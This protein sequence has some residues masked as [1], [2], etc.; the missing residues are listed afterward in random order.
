ME[1]EYLVPIH[2]E[3]FRDVSGFG[4]FY[5]I[6]SKGRLLSLARGKKKNA[7]IR[8]GFMSSNGY[9]TIR[10]RHCGYNRTATIHSIMAQ[11]FI[12]K[13]YVSH[14]LTCDHID[15]DKLN[16]SLDN[17]RLV[18]FREN[19]L[20]KGMK[21]KAGAHYHKRSKMWISNIKIDGKSLHLGS[22][23]TETGAHNAYMTKLEEI[24]R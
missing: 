4:G 12:D 13:D 11:E 15:R 20:N 14:G 16:N 1:A 19:Q 7:T 8:A 9:L 22:F 10:M 24:G 6:S 21:N 23:K 3:E 2:N 5:K 17:I 18:T